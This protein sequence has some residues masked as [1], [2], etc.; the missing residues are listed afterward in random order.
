MKKNGTIVNYLFAIFIILYEYAISAVYFRVTGDALEEATRQVI[1]G[2]KSDILLGMVIIAAIL[3]EFFGLYLKRGT[4][5]ISSGGG[6]FFLWTL[7]L[8][9]TTIMVMTACRALGA[10]LEKIGPAAGLAIL[11]NIIKELVLLGLLWSGSGNSPSRAKGFLAD[12]CILFFYCTGFTTGWDVISATPGSN[13]HQYLSN[14]PA[15]V[16]YSIAAMIFFLIMYLP[17]RI[18]YLLTERMETDRDMLVSALS[19]VAVTIA[20]MLPLYKPLD[21]SMVR[22][23]WPAEY[24]KHYEKQGGPSSSRLKP[25]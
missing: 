4:A 9:V 23:Y 12:S 13:L 25:H 22:R 24:E 18:G 17:L 11:A 1:Y 19:I 7:H 16:L 20:A 8:A 14:I 2:G 6:F 3:S 5:S 15:L 21:P 10:D